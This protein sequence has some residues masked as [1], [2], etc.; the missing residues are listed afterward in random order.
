MLCTKNFKRKNLQTNLENTWNNGE[1]EKPG[2]AGLVAKDV[3]HTHDLGQQNRNGD[4]KL[5]NSS[6]LKE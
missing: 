3:P 4:D 1:K 5:V 2:P 6:H